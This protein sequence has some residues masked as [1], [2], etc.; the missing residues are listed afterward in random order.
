MSP[1]SNVGDGA[2]QGSLP[3]LTAAC[4]VLQA[5]CNA[6]CE[7]VSQR[8]QAA[9]VIIRRHLRQGS[10]KGH[11]TV[12][13][14]CMRVPPQGVRIKI[15]LSFSKRLLSVFSV[16]PD[17]SRYASG[18][19]DKNHFH[20]ASNDLSCACLCDS[21]HVC[22]GMSVP[23]AS[24]EV[25]V[26]DILGR[27]S[28]TLQHREPP[29]WTLLQRPQRQLVCRCPTTAGHEYTCFSANHAH[30][31]SL[32]NRCIPSEIQCSCRC[33]TSACLTTWPV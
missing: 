14:L 6:F 31:A 10:V 12:L 11:P 17:A 28:S 16:P 9:D 26:L 15:A 3:T 8:V 33:R 25:N 30:A 19:A 22:R 21:A 20:L 5:M 7:F 1:H 23:A 2:S 24:V 4:V 27:L 32:A 13:Q 18:P 29:L